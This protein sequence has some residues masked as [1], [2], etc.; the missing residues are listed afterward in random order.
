MK[1]VKRII[2]STILLATVLTGAPQMAHAAAYSVSH[3]DIGGPL[4]PYASDI[5]NLGQVVGWFMTDNPSYTPEPW[6]EGFGKSRDEWH[7]FLYSDGTVTDLGVLGRLPGEEASYAY[8]FAINDVGQVVGRTDV[9]T[10]SKDA[11]G[12]RYGF[13]GFIYQNGQMSDVNWVSEYRDTY[14]V[15]SINNHGDMVGSSGVRDS[16]GYEGRTGVAE[17]DGVFTDLFDLH[18]KG[19]ATSINDQGQITG[20]MSATPW[21]NNFE[22]FLYHQ[23]QLSMMGSLG[24]EQSVG[25][26]INNLGQATGTA[27]TADGR[28]HTFLYTDGV[29]TDL[30]PDASNSTGMDINDRGVIVGSTDGRAFMFSDGVMTDLNTLIAPDSGWLLTD[31]TAINNSDVI[32]GNA[33]FNGESRLVILTPSAVPE[34]GLISLFL[35][36]VSVL[37]LVSAGRRRGLSRTGAHTPGT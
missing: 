29:M 6:D 35:A 32:V 23:G 12:G 25:N 1:F 4:A 26:R 13:R 9:S 36:G 7:P 8:A 17:L 22:A 20:T 37:G 24:G 10:T 15:Y 14:V 33:K 19:Y 27:L 16:Y 34:P 11:R 28:W 30:T 21:R 2:S 31:A 5:N 18:E 3:L